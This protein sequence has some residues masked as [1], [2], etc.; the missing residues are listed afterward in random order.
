[1]SKQRCLNCSHVVEPDGEA[2]GMIRMQNQPRYFHESPRGCQNA[3]HAWDLDVTFP[4]ARNEV[5][6]ERRFAQEKEQLITAE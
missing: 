4:E 2:I 1:M 5:H 6:T 3:E